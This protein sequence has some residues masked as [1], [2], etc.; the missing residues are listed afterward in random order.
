[1]A[2]GSTILGAMVIA[3]GLAYGGYAMG[4]AG[5]SKGAQPQPAPM[6]QAPK[7]TEARDQAMAAARSKRLSMA[8]SKSIYTSPLGISGEAQIAKKQ[9]LGQ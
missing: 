5:K 4:Q 7:P 2:A 1:M 6:P 3:G 9:L 8:R